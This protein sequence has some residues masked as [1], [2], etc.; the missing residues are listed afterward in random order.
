MNAP[1]PDLRTHLALLE[2]DETAI[3]ADWVDDPDVTALFRRCR[4]D[5]SF[6][7]ENFG[8]KIFGHYLDI[9]RGSCDFGDCPYMQEM[10]RY[11]KNKDL[12]VRDVYVLCTG[13]RRSVKHK[14][15]PYD[16]QAIRTA[17]EI[18]RVFDKNLEGVFSAYT[19]T[20][21]EKERE[22]DQYLGII[23]ENVIVSKTDRNGVI[24]DV[25]DAFA[26]I[27][28]YE[29]A[30][31]IGNR[32][33]MLRHPEMPDSLFRGL[34]Q[35]LNA[36]KNW[37]GEIK[38]RRKNGGFFWVEATISPLYDGEGNFEGYMA[39]NHD[40]THI[41]PM[42]CFV[43]FCR[44]ADIMADELLLPDCGGSGE[45]KK[46]R[47]ALSMLITKLKNLIKQEREIF[48]EAAHELKSPI[49]VLKARLG[50]FKNGDDY[51]KEE[52]VKDAAADVD[53]IIGHLKEILFLK[54]VEYNLQDLGEPLSLTA[55]VEKLR[56][57]FAP[58]LAQKNQ[59]FRIETRGD[60][61]LVQSRE[62][63]S[64]VLQAVLENVIGHTVRGGTIDLLV[65]GSVGELRLSN[66]VDPSGEGTLFS[67]K[68][69]FDTIHRLAKQMAF[70]FQ[71]APSPGN[72]EYLTT[73]RFHH[74]D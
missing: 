25:S 21:S 33:S 15:L 55:E 3:M 62:A 23:D 58:L 56:D 70:T 32:H 69:G 36:G 74:F 12:S 1:F 73:L 2:E 18:D 64:K 9:L 34:W 30:E 20:I 54:T 63:L 60:V 65:D 14:I 35:T 51:T 26:K 50:L 44:Q 59:E 19:E 11:L 67:T 4:I 29:K 43:D 37:R 72:E 45:M 41:K 10:I 53:K 16:Q 38:N 13:L 68:I 40:I 17:E 24:T 39:I 71:A 7:I 66:P 31:L 46:F 5:K 22:I 52:F 48:K 28:G 57:Y 27:S 47:D 49:A 8:K 61:A 6:F 42:E